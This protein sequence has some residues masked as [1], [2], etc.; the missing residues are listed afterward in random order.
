MA[1]FRP[2]PDARGYA[3]PADVLAALGLQHMVRRRFTT[4]EQA[5]AWVLI[6]RW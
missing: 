5:L 2:V 6:V 1:E 4:P 3:V